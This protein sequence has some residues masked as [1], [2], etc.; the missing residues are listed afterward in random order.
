MSS[1]LIIP[2]AYYI[3][4]IMLEVSQGK[5][6]VNLTKYIYALCQ[7]EF[8]QF[9]QGAWSKR[10]EHMCNKWE[11]C[12]HN[13]WKFICKLDPSA[14]AEMIQHYNKVYPTVTVAV[15]AVVIGTILA[16]E[17]EQQELIDFYRKELNARS[18]SLVD[19]KENTRGNIV[20]FLKVETD[21]IGATSVRRLHLRQ[22]GWM[23]MW[24]DDAKDNGFLE[25][26]G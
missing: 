8:R 22:N 15:D 12:D 16:N 11:E 21:D 19:T 13:P 4:V 1:K 20:H 7:P 26:R 9:A 2:F 25:F 5:E 10:W 17:T 23:I 18:V 14:F 3:K 6:F 24:A